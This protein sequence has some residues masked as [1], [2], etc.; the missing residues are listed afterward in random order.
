MRRLVLVLALLSVTLA[1]A[2]TIGAGRAHAGELQ[3]AVGLSG[4]G[5]SWPGDGA[6]VGSLRLGYRFMD[7]V[8][9]YFLG[10]AGYGAIDDRVLLSLSVGAQIWGRIRSVRPFARVGLLHNHEEPW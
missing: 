4:A 2:L 10:K 5:T 6:G 1:P 9:I 7:L 3:L 8:G